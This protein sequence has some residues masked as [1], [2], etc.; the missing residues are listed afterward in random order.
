M[1]KEDDQELTEEETEI[2]ERVRDALN[3]GCNVTLERATSRIRIICKNK[4][5]ESIRLT[6]EQFNKLAPIVERIKQEIRMA[7]SASG[8]STKQ[9]TSLLT[10]IGLLTTFVTKRRPLLEEI[11]NK[12]GWLQK[13]LL[14]IGLNVF[15]F[16]ITINKGSEDIDQN[17]IVNIL[18]EIR[19]SDRLVEYIMDQLLN[20][21]ISAQG[22]KAV[23]ELR[24]RIIMLEAENKL[25]FN[26]VSRSRVAL[27]T[28]RRLL[29][30]AISFMDQEG[31]R[32][33]IKKASILGLTRHNP[34]GHAGGEAS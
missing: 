18:G 6:K 13:A 1:T 3:Q 12:V 32:E 19:D 11:I 16:M 27:T 8:T 17:D 31:I 33:F 22:S 30:L 26:M 29:D 10:D 28:F 23:D 34:P 24:K 4:P 15:L 2:L 5:R 25:L 7:T 21:Y 9:Q 20:M 14:D